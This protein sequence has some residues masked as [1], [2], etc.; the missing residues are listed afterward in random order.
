MFIKAA[1]RSKMTSSLFSTTFVV[2]FGLVASNN[3]LPCP[4][5][6]SMNNETP[7]E[8]K[9]LQAESSTRKLNSSA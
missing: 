4:V 9:P 6:H 1:T 7:Q 2:A 8:L 5:D 3:L